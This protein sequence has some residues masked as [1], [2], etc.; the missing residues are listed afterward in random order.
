M[1][2]E[3]F[4]KA[5]ITSPDAVSINRLEDGMYVLINEGFTKLTGYSEDDVI[6]KTSIELN[7]WAFPSDRDK[8]ISGLRENGV[9]ENLEADFVMKDGGQMTGMMSATII[10]LNNVP[11]ILSI[12]RDITDKKKNSNCSS[13]E[14]KQ[15]P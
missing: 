12:T 8:L 6:G 14:R 5:F 7:I 13:E 15:V 11:H 1:S 9:V 10:E 4:R 3:K 2:E